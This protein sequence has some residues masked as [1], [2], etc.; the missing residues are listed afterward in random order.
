MKFNV[1]GHVR[2]RSDGEIH[3]SS[4][5]PLQTFHPSDV[6]EAQLDFGMRLVVGVQCE[7]M[8][9]A[10]RRGIELLLDKV[11]INI[12]STGFLAT[13]MLPPKPAATSSGPTNQPTP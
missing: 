11:G 13:V 1:C 12:V 2:Q 3:E 10:L 5:E 6:V 9:S 4:P 7:P 8:T